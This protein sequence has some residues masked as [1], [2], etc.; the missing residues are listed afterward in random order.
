MHGAQPGEHVV[1]DQNWDPGWSASGR[2][3]DNCHDT[4][5][6]ELREADAVIV[7]RYRPLA[8]WPGIALF[9]VTLGG[10]GFAYHRV[11]RARKACESHAT[12]SGRSARAST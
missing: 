9:V 11:R 10:I 7:F 2:R 12:A 4:V 6:A 1:L 8:F 5:R 3:V